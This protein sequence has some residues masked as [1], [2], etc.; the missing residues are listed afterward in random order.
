MK[1]FIKFSGITSIVILF[2]T[3][4]TKET[5]VPYKSESTLNF[6]SRAKAPYQIAF[7]NLTEYDISQAQIGLKPLFKMI[8]AKGGKVEVGMERFMILKEL[9]AIDFTAVLKGTRLRSN[10]HIMFRGQKEFEELPP[11]SYVVSIQLD[12]VAPWL[13]F[14][15]PFLNLKIESGESIEMKE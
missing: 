10:L 13:G 5:L 14:N 1:T 7:R 8:P 11:G 4:C 12:N 9:P 3:S 6:D 15:Y 2:F